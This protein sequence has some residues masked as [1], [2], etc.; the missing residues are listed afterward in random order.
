[1]DGTFLRIEDADLNPIVIQA[2]DV[3][4]VF[5]GM[6][7]GT[8]SVRAVHNGEDPERIDRL[9]LEEVIEVG[10]LLDGRWVA[11]P[12]FQPLRFRVRASSR[13]LSGIGGRMISGTMSWSS[14]Q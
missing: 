5:P 6:V 10:V 2:F 12:R 7:Q 13:K 3:D 4:I 11:I 8:Y 9:W 1:M 14:W